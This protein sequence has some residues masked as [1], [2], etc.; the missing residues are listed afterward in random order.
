MQ[1]VQP[2]KRASF[3]FILSPTELNSFNSEKLETKIKNFKSKIRTLN[4]YVL[5][6]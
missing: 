3:Y 6:Y 5:I 2:N 1:K 4:E